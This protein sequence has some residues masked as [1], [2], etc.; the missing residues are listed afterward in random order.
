[1]EREQKGN[2]EK[3]NYKMWSATIFER[4]MI[5]A[6]TLFY[7]FF[8]KIIDITLSVGFTIYI[9]LFQYSKLA[10]YTRPFMKG[11]DYHEKIYLRGM[12]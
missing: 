12:C 8:S 1:M 3:L 6:H 9:K 11:D 5:P 10:S 4:M 2:Y 7:F